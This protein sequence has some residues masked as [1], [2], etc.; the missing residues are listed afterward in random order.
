M[1]HGLCNLTIGPENSLFSRKNGFLRNSLSL[2]LNVLHGRF[3]TATERV[4]NERYPTMEKMNISRNMHSHT[5]LAHAKET[6]PGGADSTMRVLQYHL[7]TMVIRADGAR[8]WD[9][10]GNELIDMNMGYGPLIFGHRPPVVMEAI[11]SEMEQRGTLLG[12][13]HELSHKAGELIRACCPSVEKLRFSSSGTEAMQTA[14]RLARCWTNRETIILFEGHYHGSG[15]ATFHRYHAPLTQLYAGH[16]ALPGTGGMGGAPHNAYV[17]PWN[18]IG[19]LQDFVERNS[20]KIAA[21]IMEPVMGNAGVIPP[22]P[23]YLESV[24]QLAKDNG[25]LLIFDE[26]ITGFRI[27][28]GGAQERYR[29]RSDLTTFSKAMNGGVPASAVGGRA[30]IMDLLATGDVF[31]G[32]VY[33]G[34]PLSMAATLA[35]QEEYSKH[36]KRIYGYL[37]SAAN[38]LAQGVREIFCRAN[39]PVVVQN[40]GAM[41]SLW[42]VADKDNPITS[43]RDVRKHANPDSFIRFQHLLQGEGVYVHPNH[44]EPWY[45]STAHSE[46]ILASVLQRIER[47][48]DQYRKLGD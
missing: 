35:V 22:A 21:L 40:V 10:D 27:A 18:D 26:V 48:V 7:P 24:A 41:F 4:R 15:D 39:I 1:F 2:A 9:L 31:H 20:R 13:P 43:Y 33:S 38:A 34:N 28:H 16:K 45:I 25:A 17:L 8:V 36:H 12:F 30:E 14:V 44:F 23:G 19:A 32:G 46:E 37:E 6:I 11:K 3:H 29:V 5:M 47:A 42:F